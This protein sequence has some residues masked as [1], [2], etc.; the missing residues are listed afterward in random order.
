MNMMSSFW[1]TG[2]FPRIL[3][4]NGAIVVVFKHFGLHLHSTSLFCC[5]QDSVTLT[6]VSNQTQQVLVSGICAQ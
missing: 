4:H 1:G 5:G 2:L 3:S 6:I